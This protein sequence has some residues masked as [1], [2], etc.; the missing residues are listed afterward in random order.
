MGRISQPIV[1]LLS[2][3]VRGTASP[4]TLKSNTT[5]L[6]TSTDPR[7][8]RMLTPSPDSVYRGIT[9]TMG[10]VNAQ[11]TKKVPHVL[12]SVAAPYTGKYLFA[13]KARFVLM[14]YSQLQFARAEA[15]F[16]KGQLVPAYDAYIKGIDGHMDFVNKYGLT[17]GTS[18]YAAITAAQIATYKA[19][20]EVAQNPAELTIADIMGQKF[21]AQW[22]WAGIEQWNDLRKYHYDTTVFRTY[23]LIS[24]NEIDVRNLGQL[25]YRVRPRYN[26]EYVWN[27]DELTKWG[28]LDINYHTY[29][30][31]FSKP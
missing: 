16:V 7:L 30:L 27:R 15:H 29:E 21:I 23:Y 25:V 4:D 9:P 10:E 19:S 2:G 17:S 26:S 6:T 20:D 22:G 28:G 31:W 13:D 5:G 12:G 1:D 18:T 8:S 14:S 3:G 11:A 24:G